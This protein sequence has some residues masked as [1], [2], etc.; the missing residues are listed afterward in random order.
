MEIFYTVHRP[1]VDCGEPG[2]SARLRLRLKRQ[3]QAMKKVSQ[4]LRLWLTRLSQ[5][6]CPPDPL[7][8]LPLR[9]WA[10]LPFHHRDRDCPG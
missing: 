3:E 4:A 9:D 6:D 2:C 10:D 1:L 5:R 8:R 7:S